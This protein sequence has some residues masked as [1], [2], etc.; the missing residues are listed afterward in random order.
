MRAIKDERVKASRCFS[1]LHPFPPPPPPT[2]RSVIA[3]LDVAL[4]RKKLRRGGTSGAEAAPELSE[5]EEFIQ[6]HLQQHQAVNDLLDR[7]SRENFQLRDVLDEIRPKLSDPPGRRLFQRTPGVGPHT[8]EDNIKI[9]ALSI[10]NGAL[11]GLTIAQCSTLCAALKNDEDTLNS[12]NGIMYRMTEPGN[13]ANLETAYCY[14]LLSTGA[15]NPLDFASSIFSRRDTSGC[16]NPTEYDN[17]AC[18]QMSPQTTKSRV[19]DYAA[20]KT[21][22]RQGKGSPRLPRPRSALEVSMPFEPCV[23]MASY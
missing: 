19:L 5:E 4:R 15:C 3:A 1:S 21:S 14:L 20:A 2:P 10:G 18:V 12:C 9:S 8:F 11:I 16:H 13:A 17:P 23:R 22:C 7:L 6:H